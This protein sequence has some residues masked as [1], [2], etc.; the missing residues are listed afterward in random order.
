[1]RTR[2]LRRGDRLEDRMR[3]KLLLSLLALL[4]LVPGLAR[5]RPQLDP[6]RRRRPEPGD[7][8]NRPTSSS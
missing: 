7:V 4:V 6:R 2:N 8:R 3:T 5:G 1:M